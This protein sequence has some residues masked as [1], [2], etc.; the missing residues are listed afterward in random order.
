MRKAQKEPLRMTELGF[1]WFAALIEGLRI[2]N[3]KCDDLGVE[4]VPVYKNNSDHRGR[5]DHLEFDYWKRDEYM[6]SKALEKFVADKGQ[7][8]IHANYP[9]WKAIDAARKK[10]V[11][12]YRVKK[13]EALKIYRKASRRIKRRK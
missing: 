4:D 2:I 7:E 12:I 6:N 1:C 10:V 8:I 13:E 5:Q 3:D 11:R 9:N